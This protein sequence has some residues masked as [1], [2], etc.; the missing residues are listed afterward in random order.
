[1]PD[2]AE[3]SAIWPS[4]KLFGEKG[5]LLL[6]FRP[7]TVLPLVRNPEHALESAPLSV[8]ASR[9]QCLSHINEQSLKE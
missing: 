3:L 2:V 5:L 7:R 1:M 8:L 6:R 4:L 9:H